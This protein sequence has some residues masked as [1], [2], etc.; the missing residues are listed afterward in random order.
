[1]PPG[2][3]G[4]GRIDLRQECADRSQRHGV[5]GRERFLELLGRPGVEYVD[6]RQPDALSGQPLAMADQL[7]VR[8]THDIMRRLQEIT[9][10]DRYRPSLWLRRRALLGLSAATI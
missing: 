7:G 4:A 9:G 5:R 3:D 2:I 1:M 8:T 6:S 10:S